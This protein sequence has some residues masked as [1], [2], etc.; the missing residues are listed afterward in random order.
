MVGPWQCGGESHNAVPARE[1]CGPMARGLDLRVLRGGNPVDDISE[2]IIIEELARVDPSF[3]VMFC[4]HVGLCAKTIA[5][6]GNEYQK[7]EYL[8]RL[9]AGDVGAYSLSEAGAGT[10]AKDTFDRYEEQKLKIGSEAIEIDR[11]V[12]KEVEN[13]WKQQL[14]KQ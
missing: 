3:S 5:L 7:K 10:D 4:V 1:S 12:K 9:A 13:L 2:S 8:T 14:E 6:H 11:K